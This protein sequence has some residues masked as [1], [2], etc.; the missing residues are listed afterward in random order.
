[1]S[2]MFIINIL[3]NFKIDSTLLFLKYFLYYILQNNFQFFCFKT[4]VF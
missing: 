4:K 3:I 1:L 2:T